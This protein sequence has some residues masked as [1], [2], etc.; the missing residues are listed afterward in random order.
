MEQHRTNV[1]FAD[2]KGYSALNDQQLVSYGKNVLPNL[3]KR[4]DE[5]QY[6]HINAWGDGIIISSGSVI[7]I[8]QIALAIRDYFKDYNW[9]SLQLPNLDMRV[10]VHEGEI[11]KGEDPLTKSGYVVGQ[12]II[13]ASRLEPITTPGKVW[14]TDKVRQSIS[15]VKSEETK[16]LF[17]FDEIG[18]IP[19]PKNAGSHLIHMLRR[20]REKEISPQEIEKILAEAVI[21]RTAEKE[22]EKINQAGKFEIV[23]GIV[24][25]KDSVLAVQ[26]RDKSE[27]LNFMFP[28][29]KRLPLENPET[30]VAKEVKQ[31]TGLTCVVRKEIDFVKAHP[32]TKHPCRIFHLEPVGEDIMPTN[33]DED[34]NSAVFW[35][36]AS[37]LSTLFEPSSKRVKDF[38]STLCDE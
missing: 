10:S 29:G 16:R 8:C 27:G 7:E 35:Q 19:L 23:I 33:Q 17:E 37:Q 24:T 1:L 22:K 9:Q 11:F 20:P 36:R 14:V 25:Q 38:L 21:R 2:V 18:K 12:T 4:I 34:E 15:N 32:V 28:S 30:V 3:A 5:F 6:E 13:Q 31:E 26:R